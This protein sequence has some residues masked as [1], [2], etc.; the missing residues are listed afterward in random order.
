VSAQPQEGSRDSRRSASQGFASRVLAVVLLAAAY[1]LTLASVDP[2]DIAMALAVSAGALIGLRRFLLT[3]SPLPGRELIRRALRL[4]AFTLV[5][6]REIVVG[7]WQVSLIVAGLRPLSRPGI[8]EIP[9]GD[10]TPNG[11]AVTTLAITLSPGELLVD[12]DW[13]RGVMLVHVI[14]AHDPDG[15]RGR[16]E[17]IY[18]RFQRGVFP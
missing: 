10:R 13:S 18:Q 3:D 17:E 4:P 9:I 12:V 14:D 11:V 16:Y 5:V 8:V 6:L 7:T 15:I 2:L 1:L